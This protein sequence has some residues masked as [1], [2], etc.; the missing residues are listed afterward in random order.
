MHGEFDHPVHKADPVRRRQTIG[1]Q[2]QPDLLAAA[3]SGWKADPLGDVVIMKL[4]VQP[5]GFRQLPEGINRPGVTSEDKDEPG[6]C[7]DR[8]RTIPCTVQ[9]VTNRAQAEIGGDHAMSAGRS[10]HGR[11][12]PEQRVGGQLDD[13]PVRTDGT[14]TARRPDAAPGS[15]TGSSAVFP[16]V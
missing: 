6:A 7:P 14:A 3:G 10:V 16:W 2:E 13:A 11:L 8:T 12:R 9:A 15:P 5:R 4:S 1:V